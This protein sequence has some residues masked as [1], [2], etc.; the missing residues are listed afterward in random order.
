MK[1]KDVQNWISMVLSLKKNEIFYY[2]DIVS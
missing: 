1:T 2:I